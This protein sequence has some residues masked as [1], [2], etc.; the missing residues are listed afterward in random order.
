MYM[1]LLFKF[2]RHLCKVS[3]TLV[4]T[5]Y[6]ETTSNFIFFVSVGVIFQAIFPL[7]LFFSLHSRRSKEKMGL[8][9]TPARIVMQLS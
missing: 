4:T 5:D 6:Q 9:Y 2:G 1:V 7:S 3:I 8:L